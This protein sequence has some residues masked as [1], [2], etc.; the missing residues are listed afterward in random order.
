MR[1]L[2]KVKFVDLSR[3]HASIRAKLAETALRV[4]ESGNYIGGSEL[5]QFEK[6]MAAWL[7]VEEICGVGCGTSALYGA[8]KCRGIGPGD[9]VITTVH[10]AI[11]TPE[12]ITLCGADIV[13][14]D[15]EKDGF[16]I[17]LDQL[18]SK[19]GPKTKAI[20][21]V[22]LYGQP[23]DVEKA[24]RIAQKHGLF[25]IEDCAQAQGAEFAGKKVGTFGD[26]ATFSFFPSKTMGG[27]GDGGAVTTKDRDLLRKIRM[28]LNHGRE[29]KYL[30]EFE[31]TN[32]RLDALQAALL[33]HCLEQIDEWNS[34][35]REAAAIYN[36][37]LSGIDA[38]KTPKKFPNTTPVYHVYVILAPD[39]DALGA[40]LKEK[41]IDSGVHY[42]YSLNVLPAYARLNQ[43]KG[44]F[45]RAEYACEHV[46]SLPLYPGIEREEI[47]YVCETVR[48][49][50]AQ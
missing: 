23:F 19:I 36:E 26:A 47:E 31:G 48:K 6:E 34:K 2:K 42:P 39:R 22:H 35:R 10:T 3:Q 21:P 50:Y 1:P 4:I 49:F 43:G 9:E 13:F 38:I 32:S 46:L 40:H 25:M 37:H 45:P 14:C 17:D 5:K 7:G 27:F 12:S 29:S 28:F 18:E 8:L 20:I 44:Y 30:H 33:R 11:A 24:R 15:I 16:N 41:C